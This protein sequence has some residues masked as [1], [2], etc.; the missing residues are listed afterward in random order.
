MSRVGIAVS[1]LLSSL[2]SSSFDAYGS[3][4]RGRPCGRKCHD[5]RPSSSKMQVS[6]LVAAVEMSDVAPFGALR[7]FRTDEAHTSP[8]TSRSLACVAKTSVALGAR[9]SCRLP[10]RRLCDYADI[11]LKLVGEMTSPER[12]IFDAP[13]CGRDRGKSMRRSADVWTEDNHSARE[14]L[15]GEADRFYQVGIAGDDPRQLAFACK[16]VMDEERG[17]IDVRALLFEVDYSDGTRRII[18]KSPVNLVPLEM[19]EMHC[20]VRQCGKGSKEDGL[21]RTSV[22]ILGPSLD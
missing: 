14:G 1:G 5:A 8:C 4:C 16:R 2:S 9:P 17:E 18:D 6:S 3:R 10:V 7:R 22:R 20:Q 13:R 11:V 21:S 15:V 12:P 19:T